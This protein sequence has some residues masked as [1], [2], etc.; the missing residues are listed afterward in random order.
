[1]SSNNV[2][3]DPQ[4]RNGRQTA[5]CVRIVERDA[6]WVAEFDCTFYEEGSS[7]RNKKQS[8]RH[9]TGPQNYGPPTTTP[10]SRT[11]E[12]MRNVSTP[13]DT[14]A[15]HNTIQMTEAADNANTVEDSPSVKRFKAYADGGRCG[16]TTLRWRIGKYPG[17]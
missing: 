11:T 8:L 15:A 5:V 1:M 3:S 14:T 4:P 2:R 6:K 13:S 7:R 12:P 17:R 10:S 9:Q 16:V